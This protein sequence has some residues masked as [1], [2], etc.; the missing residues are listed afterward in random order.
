MKYSPNESPQKKIGNACLH[1]FDSVSEMS[2]IGDNNT[3]SIFRPKAPPPSFDDDE[4]ILLH[5]AVNSIFDDAM[6][7]PNGAFVAELSRPVT[8]S[9]EYGLDGLSSVYDSFLSPSPSGTG[10]TV[11][12][13]D[14]EFTNDSWRW[15]CFDG[16]TDKSIRT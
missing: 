3:T 15:A 9:V 7:H 8:G 5:K 16:V 4:S 12:R 6:G 10:N 14:Q 1:S 11:V 13:S 2:S